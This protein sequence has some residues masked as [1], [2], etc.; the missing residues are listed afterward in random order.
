MRESKRRTMRTRMTRKMRM[1]KEMKRTRKMRM[2]KVDGERMEGQGGRQRMTRQLGGTVC[3]TLGTVWPSQV[4]PFS[5][6][7]LDF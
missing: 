5:A 6:S 2:V 3:S 4:C 1:R 7:S